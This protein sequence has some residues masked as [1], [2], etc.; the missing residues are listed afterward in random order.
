MKI[1]T[2]KKLNEMLEA[3]RE[4]GRQTQE[5]LDSSRDLFQ[6]SEFYL[7]HP[8]ISVFSIER[9][10]LDTSN[11]QTCIGF[12]LKD[13]SG[14]IIP[15]HGTETRG[16]WHLFISRKQHVKLIEDWHK[17]LEPVVA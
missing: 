15:V 3:A 13:N 7:K 5:Q 8:N 12:L 10:N 1:L 4:E 2:D 14:N 9:L 17:S 11:E 6:Q 16:E